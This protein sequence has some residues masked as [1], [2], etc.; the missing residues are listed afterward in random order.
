MLLIFR[1]L[2]EDIH[3]FP[4]GLSTPRK[5]EMVAALNENLE[6]VFVFLLQ[7]LEV[8]L[9]AQC[10]IIVIN[11]SMILKRLGTRLQYDEKDG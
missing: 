11:I 5:R 3:T 7:N 1:R 6:S 9:S 8:I 2:S 10:C 4:E